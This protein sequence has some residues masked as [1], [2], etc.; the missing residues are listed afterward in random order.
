MSSQKTVATVPRPAL[1]RGFATARLPKLMAAAMAFATFNTWLYYHF[2]FSE[3]RNAYRQFYAT[4]DADKVYEE[5]KKTGIFH[6]TAV[7]NAD[8]EE[9]EEE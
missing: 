7:I 9:E 1:M 2:V 5:M 3:R 6:S 8:V 4:Y